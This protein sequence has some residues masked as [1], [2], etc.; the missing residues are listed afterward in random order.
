MGKNESY[1]QKII[2]SFLGCFYFM[3]ILSFTLINFNW[4]MDGYRMSL[5]AYK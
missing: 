1:K 3:V 4:V 5:G 2:E